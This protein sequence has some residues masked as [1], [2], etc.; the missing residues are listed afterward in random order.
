MGPRD[1]CP[2]PAL[3][4]A[5]L[6]SPL[7]ASPVSSTF[8]SQR[9]RQVWTRVLSLLS[10]V[11]HLGQSGVRGLAHSRRS[12]KADGMNESW[13]PNKLWGFSG[14]T[15]LSSPP[16]ANHRARTPAPSRAPPQ[17]RST[18]PPAPTR[19]SARGALPALTKDAGPPAPAAWPRPLST[20][21]RDPLGGATRLCCVSAS[22]AQ[23]SGPA[24]GASPPLSAA[25]QRHRSHRGQHSRGGPAALG[26][27]WQRKGFTVLTS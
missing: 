6:I 10:R 24:S 15:L 25:E 3:P 9:Q 20:G 11:S 19:S 27:C 17:G 12:M 1:P 5:M 23:P 4:A 14:R 21:C 26:R 7:Q 13:K 22:P 18:V 8:P 2:S 16:R